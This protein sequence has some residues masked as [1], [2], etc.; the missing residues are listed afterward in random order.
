MAGRD[1]YPVAL[2]QDSDG[3]SALHLSLEFNHRFQPPIGEQLVLANHSMNNSDKHKIKEKTSVEDTKD[4]GRK[5]GWSQRGREQGGPCCSEMH[6]H[7]VLPLNTF[8]VSNCGTDGAKPRR[9]T[10]RIGKN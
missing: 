6:A 3:E 1:A 9:Y 8:S 5:V 7:P 4:T 10:Q 2:S